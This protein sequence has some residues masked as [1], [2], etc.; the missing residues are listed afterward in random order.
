MKHREEIIGDCRL[1]LGDCL[2]VLRT[3]PD[4]SVHCCVTSPPYFGLRDY[5]VDGQIGLEPTPDEYV[6][7]LVG[8]FREVRRVL[9]D[10]GTLWLNLGDSYGA[11]GS[12]QVP[13]TK[14]HTGSGFAGA[15]RNGKT[16]LPAK[17]LIGIPW[18]VAFALQADGW[19]LRSDII[20]SKPNP[21]PES[22][23]DRPTR[24]HEYL[25]LMAKSERYYYDHEAIKEPMS[26]SSI[27]R[28][29]QPN[30]DLQSGSDRVPGKTNGPMKA[31][32]KVDKQRGH[33]RRHAGFNDRWDAMTKE[34]QCSGMRNKR[35]VWEIATTPYS[36]AHFAVFP[37]KLIEPCIM[38][39][40]PEGGTV[41]DCFGGS[42]TTAVVAVK[43]DRK[44]ILIELNGEYIN[45]EMIRI[46]H[47]INGKPRLFD[48]LP[49]PK[50]MALI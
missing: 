28:L 20:W 46:K 39:G 24:A 3:L 32:G 26:V 42:G 45:L 31:V 15:N 18:R 13:Q 50:Q 5:G 23:T 47:A 6:A 10:D 29:T 38:A 9:R 14:C 40:C 33:G 16:G 8:V 43:N 22:V 41:L 48:A 19:Y 44:A 49:K 2:T 7:A 34:N 36:G 35:S 11:N 37:E 12:N 27:S 21:M 17:N 4:Q 1:I 30:I 25:F